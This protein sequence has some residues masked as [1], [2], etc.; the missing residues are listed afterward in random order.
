MYV[1]PRDPHVMDLLHGIMP[2]YIT[3]VYAHTY[4]YTIYIY[5]N[6]NTFATTVEAS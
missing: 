5:A 6:V 1:I 3:T 2:G 4:V